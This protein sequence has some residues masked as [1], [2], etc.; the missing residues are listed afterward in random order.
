[1]KTRSKA[2]DAD[3]ARRDQLRRYQTAVQIN[4]EDLATEYASLLRLRQLLS[5]H[6]P[7]S[8]NVIPFPAASF[9]LAPPDPS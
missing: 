6:K 3:C 5:P 1:M 4:A 2:F 9:S 8:T 7:W